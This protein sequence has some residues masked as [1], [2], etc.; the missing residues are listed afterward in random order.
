MW[1]AKLSWPVSILVPSLLISSLSKRTRGVT[2]HFGKM[3]AAIGTALTVSSLGL[4]VMLFPAFG[5]SALAVLFWLI[6]TTGVVIGIT[7][8]KPLAFVKP[9]CTRC[10]LL[11]VI[12]EHEALH[13]A[14]IP[15]ELGVWGFM[16][17]RHSVA[18]LSLEGDPT[19]CSFCPI[20]K[21]LK[22]H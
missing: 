20:P 6:G 10:R 12:K 11:P 4:G 5:L 9:I 21:R 8:F 22:E 19:I 7:A 17:A 13:V 2:F 1:V 14:G 16:R 15:D 18:S 3:G